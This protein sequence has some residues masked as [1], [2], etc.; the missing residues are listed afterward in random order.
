PPEGDSSSRMTNGT[1]T[2]PQA[3]RGA[4]VTYVADPFDA[5]LERAMRYEADA[6]VVMEGGRITAHGPARDV[7]P[8]LPEGTP[9]T[10]YPDAI[11][12][13]CCL[14]AHVHYAQTS[15]IGAY[16]KQLLEWLDRY[17][18]PAELAFRDEAHARE[19]A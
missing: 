13:A 8:T 10:A 16:G 15:I 5:G 12:M 18:F 19:V 6:V 11:I 9:V 14:D 3:I 4:T 1:A 17:A 7:L 2:T